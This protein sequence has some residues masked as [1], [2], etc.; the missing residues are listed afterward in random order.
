MPP[1]L[2]Y[3]SNIAPFGSMHITDCG[4]TL[5]KS[6]T[7]IMNLFLDCLH[8]AFCFKGQAI[9]KAVTVWISS[10]TEHLCRS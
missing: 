5:I 1:G 3:F 9:Q 8:V 7:V 10:D 2:I 4:T 6:V